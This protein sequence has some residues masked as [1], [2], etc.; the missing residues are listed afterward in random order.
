MLASCSLALAVA[1][2]T[3]AQAETFSLSSCELSVVQN[4]VD[5]AV[6]GDT[7]AIPAGEC[8]WDD[9]LS[10]TNKSIAVIGAGMDATSELGWPCLD[11]IGRAPGPIGALP[12]APLY[13]WNNGD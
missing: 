7:I 8:T 3:A 6:N 12:S 9:A 1:A 5:Q 2:P 13:A 4:A 10:W 11:Q